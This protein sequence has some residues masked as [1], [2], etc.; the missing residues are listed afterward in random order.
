M[1]KV[2]FILIAI[3]INACLFAQA[4]QRMSY[5][6]VIRNAGNQLLASQPIGI[7]ISIL[8]GSGSGTVLY[9][10][11]HLTG[12]NENGLVSIEIGGGLPATGTWDAINWADGPFFIKTETDPSGGTDYTIIG[13]SQLLSVPYALHAK[14]AENLS[15]GGGF[16]HYVGELYGGG[17]VVGVWK[18]SGVEHGLIAS[19]KDLSPSA[20]WSD[21][22]DA[23]IGPAAQ[24]LVNGR[25]NTAAIIAQSANPETAAWLCDS[26]SY[27]GYSDWYL[28][29]A[30]ELNM[31]YEAAFVVNTILGAAN[32]FQFGVYWSST[33][34]PYYEGTSGWAKI[35]YD[36]KGVGADK[37]AN[38][39]VRAVRRF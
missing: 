39:R 9:V 6:A 15:G 12:T 32:G 5:Q 36:G 23:A 17:I 10:E 22:N 35:F 38:T 2:F 16:T 7:R 8:Q 25:A 30:W 11:T 27:D 26:Y 28:P 20:P 24:S 33:E 4:P 1:K 13:S 3:L 14:T 21:V 29:A 31:C 19:L 37:S 18:E 34:D